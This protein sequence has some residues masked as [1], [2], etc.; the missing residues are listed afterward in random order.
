L[1]A[2]VL[3]LAGCVGPF[4]PSTRIYE[5]RA[6]MVATSQRL[7]I[8]SEQINWSSTVKGYR[9]EIQ[10]PQGVYHVEA[11]DDDYWYYVAPQQVSLGKNK[12]FADQDSNALDGGIF[13][14]RHPGAKYASGAYVDFK[15]HH[16]L[17]LFFFDWRFT[18]KEGDQWHYVE[19]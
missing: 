1:F 9:Y 18:R 13:I 8:L 4:R 6:S 12:F 19:E 11:R 16:K 2:L 7:L 3:T 17:L 15:H 10:L 14:S 5:E